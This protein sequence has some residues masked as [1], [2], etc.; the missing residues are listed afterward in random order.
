MRMQ[1]GTYEKT[2]GA[3]GGDLAGISVVIVTTSRRPAGSS[4]CPYWSRAIRISAG[5][6]GAERSAL[7]QEGAG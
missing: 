2:D 1:V 3:E 7:H 6:S 5:R 4:R